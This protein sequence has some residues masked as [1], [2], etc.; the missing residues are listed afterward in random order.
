MSAADLDRY[1]TL[2]KVKWLCVSCGSKLPVV[3][4]NGRYTCIYC[5]QRADPA[6][7]ISLLFRTDWKNTR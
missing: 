7:G 2:R 4:L 1:L 3:R 6:L 5:A